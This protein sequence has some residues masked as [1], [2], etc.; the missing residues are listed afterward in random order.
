LAER[1]DADDHDDP[2]DLRIHCH[3][4]VAD[5]FEPSVATDER[6]GGLLLLPKRR[7][8]RVS[9]APKDYERLRVFGEDGFLIGTLA[10]SED[11][12]VTWSTP[13]RS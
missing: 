5:A 3:R 6:S 2:L 11:G 13:K 1:S 4:F 7:V 10:C 12:R 9:S 8:L